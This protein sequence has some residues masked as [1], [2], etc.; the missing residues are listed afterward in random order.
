MFILRMLRCKRLNFACVDRLHNESDQTKE[1]TLIL[2]SKRKWTEQRTEKRTLTV[3]PNWQRRRSLLGNSGKYIIV[4]ARQR[5]L[6]YC[7][8]VGKSKC[9][10]S[11]LSLVWKNKSRLWGHLALCLCMYSHH[12]CQAT[13]RQ[14]RS[15]CNE[16]TCNNRRIAGHVASKEIRQVIL[17]RNSCYSNNVWFLFCLR[18]WLPRKCRLWGHLALCLC[19]YSPHRCQATARQTRSRD[20][21]STCN[22]RRIAGHVASKKIRRLLLPRNSCYSDNV[23]FLFCLRWW[24]PRKCVSF[25]PSAHKLRPNFLNWTSILCLID[26]KKIWK[27]PINWHSRKIKENSYE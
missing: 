27:L 17:P 2:R 12:R 13:A 24:L 21:E 14:T 7:I 18:W 3:T 20:N 26:E 10:F 6:Y 19:M 23:W 22:N 9:F 4:I 11:L 1:R 16:S 5:S 8:W 25:I 15:R